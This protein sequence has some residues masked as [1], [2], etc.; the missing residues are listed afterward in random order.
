M[1]E[2]SKNAHP[3]EVLSFVNGDNLATVATDGCRHVSQEIELCREHDSLY[4]A[5]AYL[6]GKG[7]TI[8]T[9]NFSTI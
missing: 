6:E 3:V 1:I 9:S 8:D 4:K 2:T 5:I 7:Y